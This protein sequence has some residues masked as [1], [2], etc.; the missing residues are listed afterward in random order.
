MLKEKNIIFLNTLT[1]WIDKITSIV[2]NFVIKPITL[3]ILGTSM[4]G[5]LEML[6]K[7]TEFMA[8]ADFRSATTVK[9]ILSVERDKTPFDV[10]NKK[11]SAGFF[12][13]LCTLP[14]YLFIG[15]LIIYF[16]PIVTKVEE[17][18]YVSI[19]VCASLLV[20]SFIVTQV[21][22]IYEQILQGMNIVYKRM[23]M[24][25]LITILGGVFTYYLLS[26]GYGLLGVVL[27]N[28]IVVIITGISYWFVV[29][30]NL[31]WVRI[32]IVPLNEI[33]SFIKLSIGFMI[34]KI[35]SVCSRS[36]D[37]LLLGYFLSASFVS[38]YSISSYVYV[39][40]SGFIL[41]F[42]SS[43]VTNISPLA[44]KEDKSQLI[45]SRSHMWFLQILIYSYFL[46]LV[47]FLNRSFVSIWSS[48][49]L[50]VGTISNILIA[51]YIILRC[52]A[53]EERSFLC[54][55]MEIKKANINAFISF[56]ILL[57]A[58]VTLINIFELNGLLL[59]LIISQMTMVILNIKSLKSIIKTDN[60]F[61]FKYVNF[62][63][64]TTVLCL[65]LFAVATNFK[66]KIESWLV[67]LPF[68]FFLAAFCAVVY[69]LIGL[70]PINKKIVNRYI[71]IK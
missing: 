8:S 11:I 2:V 71:K 5:V 46:I 16:A 60:L 54:M 28:L 26:I 66:I 58:C 64:V 62:R 21:F 36:I 59:G 40:L 43:F 53:D 70:S 23:G 17:D 10:L 51:L 7:M 57:V 34:E 19:R 13:S 29:K 61:T 67:F 41:M 30:E 3:G 15:V 22:F 4:F 12:A 33:L 38:Q 31:K 50:Y 47:T 69:Y 25:A 6:T 27:S 56:I 1:G 39:S 37:V 35:I 9:W 14:I 68:A 18:M 44:H 49:D 52:I 42:M 55:F 24:R 32:Q 45:E 63:F 20:T 65:F 48:S